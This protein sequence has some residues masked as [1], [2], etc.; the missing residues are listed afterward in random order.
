M[1]ARQDIIIHNETAE[2]FEHSCPKPI[3]FW[4]KLLLRGSVKDSDTILDP[5]M[6][7]GT[8]LVAAK[9]LG[10]KATGIE[11]SERYCQIAK[12]RLAQEILF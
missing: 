1:G 3:K 9:M 4:S 6:G 10:R 11:I 12:D 2:R 5:F 8:T 7:S